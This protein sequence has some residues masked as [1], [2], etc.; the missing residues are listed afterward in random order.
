[1]GTHVH[2]ATVDI[3]GFLETEEP[4]AVGTVIEDVALE[5]VS[6]SHSVK[7]DFRRATNGCGIDGNSSRLGE[8]V[9]ILAV[10]S[11]QHVVLDEGGM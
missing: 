7:T 5:K 1:M 2:N 6:E 8:R 9:C 4:C 11:F 10:Y 3:A